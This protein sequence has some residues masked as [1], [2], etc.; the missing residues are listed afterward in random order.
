M[1]RLSRKVGL[2]EEI[3]STGGGD[4]FLSRP[5]NSK[6]NP[7]LLFFFL[8]IYLFL[9]M[10]ILFIYL[11]ENGRTL[12]MYFAIAILMAFSEASLTS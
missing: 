2:A 8:K 12:K 4:I 6:Q 5:E 11:T 9:Y 7:G 1:C 10:Y 3:C